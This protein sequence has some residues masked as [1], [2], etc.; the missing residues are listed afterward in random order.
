MFLATRWR[1]VPFENT[2]LDYP[3]EVAAHW[4]AFWSNNLAWDQDVLSWKMYWGVLGY[5]DV[6]YPDLVYALARWACVA[7][8]V[9]LPVLSWRFTPRIR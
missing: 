2:R 6:S 4:A 9:A 5:A 3:D 1:G 8:L 7:L